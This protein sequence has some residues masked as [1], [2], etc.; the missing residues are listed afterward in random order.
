MK[1]VEDKGVT[2]FQNTPVEAFVQVTEIFDINEEKSIISLIFRLT[3]KW[4]D[5]RVTF[6]FLKENQEKNTL[7]QDEAEHIWTPTVKFSFLQN[8]LKE[9]ERLITV[10]K[11]G[12]AKLLG[13]TCGLDKEMDSLHPIESYEGSQNPIHMMTE[14]Q[15][16]FNCRF[17]NIHVYPF[18]REV[19]T[20]NI[21]SNYS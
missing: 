7:E 4:Y 13:K 3:L 2:T 5:W 11:C 16:V 8:D 18:D 19:C 17:K 9:Q 14:Y 6:N 12:N 15:S 1:K 10:E 20:I 21:Q